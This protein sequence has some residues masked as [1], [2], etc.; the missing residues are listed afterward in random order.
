LINERTHP[1]SG[2]SNKQELSLEDATLSTV[3]FAL[4]ADNELLLMDEPKVM[5]NDG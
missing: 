1:S 2:H 3:E 5:V 4:T